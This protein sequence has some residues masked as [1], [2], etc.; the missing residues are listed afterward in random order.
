[1]KCILQLPRRRSSSPNLGNMGLMVRQPIENREYGSNDEAAY[2]EQRPTRPHAHT[3]TRPHAHTPTRPHL[4]PHT[5]THE[6]T[7]MR[8]HSHF[9]NVDVRI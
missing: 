7:P 9:F 1:M 8:T 4:H 2:R 5:H 3:P 6:H